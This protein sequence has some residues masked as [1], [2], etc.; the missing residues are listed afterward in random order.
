MWWTIGAVVL[1]GALMAALVL[2]LNTTLLPNIKTKFD[3]LDR[4]AITHTAY[5]WSSDGSDRFTTTKPN[6]NLFT[7]TSDKPSTKTGNNWNIAV[8]G[9]N[10]TPKVGQEYTLS[11]EVPEAD[12]TVNIEVFRWNNAGARVDVLTSKRTNSGEKGYVTFTWPDP[13]NSGATQIAAN[14]AW[15]NGT[16]TGTYSYGKSK[17]EIGNTPTTYM[18]SASEVKASDQT[19]IL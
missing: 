17:L 16:D 7:G 15:T 14:L 19:K 8:I 6:L 12:H 2:L 13:G 9:V 11:V 1:G 5:S 3:E 4:S 10:K 18:P